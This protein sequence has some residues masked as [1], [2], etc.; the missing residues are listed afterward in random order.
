MAG[1]LRFVAHR[2]LLAFLLFTLVF[3]SLPCGRGLPAAAATPGPDPFEL[4]VVLEELHAHIEASRLN[5]E[6]GNHAFAARHA[7]HPLQELWGRV[8]AQLP[9]HLRESVRAGLDRIEQA[10]R[11]PSQP[12]KFGE[13]LERFVRGPLAEAKGLVPVPAGEEDAFWARVMEELLDEAA[14]EYREGV[15][16]G[17]I[18]NLEEYQ[19]ARGFAARA[20]ALYHRHGRHFYPSAR[21]EL[22][23]ALED[24][25][26]AIQELADPAAVDTLVARAR[27]LLASAAYRATG[28]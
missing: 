16:E 4:A 8:E 9:Q 14:E 1:A 24:L 18:A 5:Y 25:A 2:V 13:A 26:R 28:V 19:D 11:Q 7:L 27:K 21:T 22:A 23:G 15:S 10:A 3:P 6:V 17:H 20:V 12:E